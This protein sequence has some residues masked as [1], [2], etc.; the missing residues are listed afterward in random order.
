MLRIAIDNAKEFRIGPPECNDPS[1]ILFISRMSQYQIR[2][3]RV[4]SKCKQLAATLTLRCPDS[5]TLCAVQHN[6]NRNGPY[7]APYAHETASVPLDP[8]LTAGV[9]KR[10]KNSTVPFARLSQVWTAICTVQPADHPQF[11][12]LK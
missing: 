2:T 10:F 11:G 12:T 9:A 8:A 6:V 1:G 5:T 7:L 4:D 3:I